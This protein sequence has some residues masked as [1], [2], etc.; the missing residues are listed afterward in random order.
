MSKLVLDANLRAKLNG[1]NEQVEVL[2]EQGK[3][4]GHFV[5][6]DIYQK[7]A[8]AWANAQVRDDELSKASKE[9]GG[10]TLAHIWKDLGR[11]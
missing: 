2:D 7:L 4:V 6:E 5:P 3:S 8:C 10:R 11:Q 1:L 9:T